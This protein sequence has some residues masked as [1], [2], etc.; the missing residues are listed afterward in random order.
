[1][2]VL[3]LYML[4][5]LN[6][7]EYKKWGWGQLWGVMSLN[8]T[9]SW[10]AVFA[11]LALLLVVKVNSARPE[12][13]V[14]LT[15]LVILLLIIA[16]L[17][18]LNSIRIGRA[19]EVLRKR[20][21]RNKKTEEELGKYRLHLEDLVKERTIEL[22]GAILALQSSLKQVGETQA[23][24]VKS[25]KMAALGGLVAGVAHEIN[26]PI[27][28]GVTAVSF[29][30][31]EVER[32]R[33]RCADT[34]QKDTE[35]D[36]FMDTVVEIS[37]N[38]LSN[39]KRAADLVR[40]FKQVAVDQSMEGSRRVRIAN[41]INEIL[42]TLTPKYK[43]TAHTIKMNCPAELELEI[44]PGAVSQIVTN[45]VMNSLIHG[46]EG[47]E[48]GEILFDIT[49]NDSGTCIRYRDNGRGMDQT[50]LARAFEHF[51]TTNRQQGGTG[52]GLNIVHNLVTHKL[53]GSIE[54]TSEPGK[55]VLFTILIPTC[56]SS[57]GK[58]AGLH[59]KDSENTEIRDDGDI[60]HV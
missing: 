44:D 45:L 12:N 56:D 35:F 47:I 48:K 30:G 23:Q 3:S 28:I 25:E 19:G 9:V 50:T 53:A 27:G 34:I 29:L 54:C 32:I 26:T 33:R 10:L 6:K 8:K 18:V 22:D 39:L 16:V 40:S 2:F 58:P 15:S 1:M 17:Q 43:K 41:Y 13:N 20:E 7:I 31:N 55:G 11:C 5:L 49:A 57:D 59:P 36:A 21:E 51:F 14:L 42:L 37:S 38:V 52:L 4:K 24:L 60:L 46:F